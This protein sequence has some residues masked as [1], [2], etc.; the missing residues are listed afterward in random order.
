MTVSI[1]YNKA[2][3]LKSATD[4]SQ[5]P[6]DNGF[7]VAFIGR[8]NAGKSS[9]LN[10]IT[11]IKNLARVSSTPG[12]TQMI[13]LFNLDKERRLVDLPGYGYAK[14]PRTVQQ[15]WIEATNEYLKCRQCLRGLILLMDIR[16][17][18]KDSDRHIIEWTVEC[19]V[20][21][22]ILLSKSDKLKPAAKRVSLKDV[23]MQLERYGAAVSVQ[24]FSS[25]DRSGLSE[26]Q[27]V[28]NAWFESESP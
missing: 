28:L 15:R 3:F 25:H 18:L 8:S 10:T 12:R 7:E 22:H 17:P 14:A 23:Q 13:N 26:V 11:G 2:E 20:P 21:L 5:L 16:H 1:D 24:L 27:A 9:A 6:Q 19:G 4:L